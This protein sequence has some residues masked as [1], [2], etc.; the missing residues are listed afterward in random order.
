MPGD[1]IPMT[2][3]EALVQITL[4][5]DKKTKKEVRRISTVQIS[6]D[7]FETMITHYDVLDINI[8]YTN[9]EQAKGGHKVAQRLLHWVYP[10]LANL[11]D[12]H[13]LMGRE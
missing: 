11:T 6:P 13:H 12:E 9:R 3:P 1:V 7:T 4:L 5:T 8:T 2:M 10:D